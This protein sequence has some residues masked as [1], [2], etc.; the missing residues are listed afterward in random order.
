MAARRYSTLYNNAAEWEEP[1]PALNLFWQDV[2][3]AAGADTAGVLDAAILLNEDTPMAFAFVSASEPE[4]ITI[5]HRPRSY[6]IAGGYQDRHILITGDLEDECTPYLVHQDH[7]ETVNNVR[8]RTDTAAIQA[9]LV[10]GANF[11]GPH[12]G[13]A[14]GTQTVNVIKSCALPPTWVSRAVR[15]GTY[16]F[17]AFYQA[18]LHAP[19]AAGVA[20]ALADIQEVI[21]FWSAAVTD[22][23]GNSALL[24]DAEVVVMADFRPIM[25]WSRRRI[26][27]V[28]MLRVGGP[29]GP[30]GAVTNAG[31]NTALGRIT[32]TMD[33]HERARVD[34]QD[35]IRNRSFTDKYGAHI[36]Q[37]SHIVLEVAGD[38]AMPEI[39][40]LLARCRE[41]SREKTI[42]QGG[43]AA[44]IA[45]SP[46]PITDVNAPMVTQH[47]VEL[48][49]KGWSWEKD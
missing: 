44:A 32:T 30:A 22:V 6:R 21:N 46:L 7:A 1:N 15:Q 34:R 49:R 45:A 13:G 23:G 8:I 26:I 31:L 19:I 43:L 29:A 10:G 36:A 16:T 28:D 40:R 18:F 9:A 27:N 20:A 41:S 37:Q 25:A 47:M 17:D 39:H 12:A 42:I 38:A 48:F 24:Q 11:D 3:A 2:G 4:V 35:A 33:N 14:A 5:G